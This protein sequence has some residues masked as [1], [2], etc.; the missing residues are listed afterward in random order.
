MFASYHVRR[1]HPS[2]RTQILRLHAEATQEGRHAAIDDASVIEALLAEP[3]P[4]LDRLIGEGHYFI[5]MVGHRIIAGAGW[6]P[7]GDVATMRGVWVNP[8]HRH[9]GVDRKLVEIAEDAAVTAGYDVI[10]AP[11][12]AAAADMF[13]S[14]GYAAA[15]AVQVELSAGHRLE[16][17]KMWK[18]AA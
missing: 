10:L 7:Q 5:A 12:D 8:Q 13:E 3:A 11:V 14:L 16:R 1:A 15:G 18:Q 9:S 4:Q 17:H 6:A 2:D